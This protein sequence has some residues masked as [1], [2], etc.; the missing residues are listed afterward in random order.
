MFR[1]RYAPAGSHPGTLVLDNINIKPDIKI[2]RY[3][4]TQLEE[5]SCDSKLEN[6]S[7]FEKLN[8]L[9][10][11]CNDQTK[12]ITW[13]DLSSINN[14]EALRTVSNFYNLH[15]LTISD[16]VHIPQRP[17]IE[18]QES[19]LLIITAI[20]TLEKDFSIS[21]E[22][23]SIVVGSNFVLTFQE[24][25]GDVFDPVRNRIRAGKG[26][27]RKSGSDYLAY[28][29]IDAIID[30]Y[31]PILENLGYYLEE[32]EDE[33]VS[34]PNKETL[35]KIHEIK[36]SLLQLR[37]SIWPHREIFSAILRDEYKLFK[38]TTKTYLRD[39]YDHA[40][41]I[42]DV[43]E[44]Y[45]ELAA[46]FMDLYLSSISNRLND[47]MKVLTVISTIF[48]PLSFVAGVYG[49]NFENMPELKTQYG[50]PILLFSMLFTGT[51]MLT[52]FWKKGW[53]S[54]NGS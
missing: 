2:F 23:V 40:I 33:L 53:L 34:S 30:I 26:N 16:I 6:E 52:F 27:I 50:Y 36:R 10:K 14:E 44:T 37:R 21:L 54:S 49:M 45:R 51:L 42:I 31:F 8:S 35:K 20:P 22:Q 25:E 48:M 7:Y 1:K 18:D 29:L 38:K 11:D 5:N 47:V 17:K 4:P 41:E 28:A 9:L 3:S 24:K 32:L 19:Y 46:A 13:I 39:L 12:E 15:D 43:V